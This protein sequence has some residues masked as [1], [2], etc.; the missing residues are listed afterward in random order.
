MKKTK[1]DDRQ[2]LVRL[3][4]VAKRDLGLDDETYRSVLQRI[5]GKESSADLSDP[6]LHQVL[7]HMKRSGFKVRS[8]PSKRPLAGDAQSKMVRGLWL[9]LADMGVVRDATEAALGAFVLR[10]MKVEALQWL[11]TEQASQLIEHLKLWRQ[12]VVLERE[13]KML[14]SLRL[15]ALRLRAATESILQEAVAHAIGR[16]AAMDQLSADEFKAVLDHFAVEVV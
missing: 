14:A 16:H 6:Q 3:T 11:S 1:N 5:G 10:M 2:R 13:E 7:E 4:H 8:K 9:H 12:R 15:P